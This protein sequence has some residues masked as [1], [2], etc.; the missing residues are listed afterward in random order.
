M[1]EV[2]FLQFYAGKSEAY[3]RITHLLGA[4][5]NAHIQILTLDT[6]CAV[7]GLHKPNKLRAKNM[8][9][10]SGQSGAVITSITLALG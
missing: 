9:M 2:W 1:T 10:D 3:G 7:C 6:N 8:V 5:T 4:T